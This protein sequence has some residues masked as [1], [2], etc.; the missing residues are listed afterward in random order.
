MYSIRPVCFSAQPFCVFDFLI[1]GLPWSNF[2]SQTIKST[3]SP[4]HLSKPLKLPPCIGAVSS[5][6]SLKNC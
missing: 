2:P 5:V 1:K 6:F 4:T 3:I